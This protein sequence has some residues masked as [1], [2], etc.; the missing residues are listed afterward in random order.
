V[1]L[2]IGTPRSLIV[3]APHPDDE[4]IGAYGLMLRS[5][6]RGIAVRV[7]V[8]TDGAASHPGSVAW[9]RRRL[10]RERQ[11]ETRRAIRRIGGCAGHVTFLGLPDGALQVAA[12]RRGITATIYRAAKP[13]LIVGPAASDDHPDH[14]TC[15]AAIRAARLPGMRCL[16]YPVWPA[17]DRLRGARS[18]PLTTRERLAKR[19]AIRSYRTQAGCIVD[20]PDGFAMTPAQIA[21]FSR[22]VETFVEVRR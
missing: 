10:V 4:T 1:R 13:A 7:V 9:P 21:A 17:G 6:R 19:H 3:I 15:A 20:D 12:A 2:R 22:P 16:A 8:V 5:R 11:R 14:R 18:L